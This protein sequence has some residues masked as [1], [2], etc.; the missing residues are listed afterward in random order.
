MLSMADTE[1]DAARLGAALLPAVNN[2]K[3]WQRARLSY[4]AA[5][6]HPDQLALAMLMEQEKRAMQKLLQAV[7]E[8]QEGGAGATA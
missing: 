5:C 4:E 8:L 6:D 3:R 2:Y 7:D 1:H